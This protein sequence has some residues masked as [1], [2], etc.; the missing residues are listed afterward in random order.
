MQLKF[1][2][3]TKNN[4]Y[5]LYKFEKKLNTHFLYFHKILVPSDGSKTAT[6]KLSVYIRAFYDMAII[7]EI[8]SKVK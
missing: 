7:S 8:L 6:D 2:K 5:T 3:Y 4:K 1:M